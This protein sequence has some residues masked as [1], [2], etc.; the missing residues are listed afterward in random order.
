MHVVAFDAGG[1]SDG[2]L[3]FLCSVPE[4]DVRVATVEDEFRDSLIACE[5][6]VGV[7]I[8]GPDHYFFGHLLRR[9]RRE[10]MVAPVLCLTSTVPTPVL[11]RHEMRRAA[12]VCVSLFAA[13]AD[14][15][16]PDS[17]DPEELSA[18]LR[19]LLRRF[20]QVET[21]VPY[22]PLL[23][24]L[25][26]GRVRNTFTAAR[27]TLTQSEMAVFACLLE[28]PGR[29]VLSGRLLQASAGEIALAPG[30]RS[31]SLAKVMVSRIRTKVR[32]LLYGAN[33]VRSVYGEGYMLIPYADLRWDVA[34]QEAQE[35]C[36]AG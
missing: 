4:F 3:R 30:E 11:L 15:V 35:S 28:F 16:Q 34:V 7:L 23:V 27:V 13:G 19:V 21:D 5:D 2:L 25:A 1:R 20:E 32:P 10:R 33:P 22:G 6:V 36:L 18:R 12:H 17:I 29:T 8:C 31:T 24:D 14:D 26:S 9:W